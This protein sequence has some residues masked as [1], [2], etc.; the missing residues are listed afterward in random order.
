MHRRT[1]P[2]GSGVPLIVTSIVVA[3][4]G[5]TGCGGSH[6]KPVDSAAAAPSDAGATEGSAS[7]ASGDTG[8]GVTVTSTPATG[9]AA[10]AP[11]ERAFAKTSA[12]ATSLID[13][14]IDK[15]HKE[16][17]VCVHAARTRMKD[18][19]AAVTVDIGIDQEGTLIGVKNPK[20]HKVDAA[21][22]QC[23]LAALKGAPFPRSNAGVITVHK[24]FTDKVVFPE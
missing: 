14:V 8:T 17:G 5:V 4:A 12:E 6:S 22:N 2:R 16:I 1:L 20:G 13:D 10:P 11:D 19:H 21:L 7:G 3:L 9:S 24:T 18:A 15:H 23:I